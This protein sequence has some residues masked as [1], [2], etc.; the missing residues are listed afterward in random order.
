MGA[1]KL[2][3]QANSV[4]KVTKPKNINNQPGPGNTK[5]TIPTPTKKNP[6]K[7]RS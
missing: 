4:A 2:L 5:S 6:I 7:K 1:N 3:A